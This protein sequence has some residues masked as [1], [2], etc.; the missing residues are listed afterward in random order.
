MQASGDWGGDLGVCTQDPALYA[1]VLACLATQL[2]GTVWHGGYGKI[3]LFLL[4]R[5]NFLTGGTSC[6]V[7][8]TW[9]KDGDRRP[10]RERITCCWVKLSCP[11]LPVKY[12][13]LPS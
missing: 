13:R 3:S 7:L 10:L 6:L 12:F 1:A 9:S 2:T 8:L 4:Y 11:K 5:R